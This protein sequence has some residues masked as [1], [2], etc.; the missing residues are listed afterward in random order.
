MDANKAVTIFTVVWFGLLSSYL[1]G[2]LIKIKVFIP[3]N[4]RRER[5]YDVK[6]LFKGGEK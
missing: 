1:A 5:L 3:L 6:K 4:N 2:V